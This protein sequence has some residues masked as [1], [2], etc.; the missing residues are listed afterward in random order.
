[1]ISS[2]RL[3]NFR[4]FKDSSFDFGEQVNIIVG[5]NAC[6][7]TS[8][9]EGVLVN[10]TG[11]SYRVK[12]PLLVRE[13]EEWFRVDIV[14][15]SINRVIKYQEGVKTFEIEENKYKRLSSNTKEP[16]VL[17][18]PNILNM[19]TSSPEGR[20]SYID[21]ILKQVDAT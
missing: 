3:Q 9:I 19:L 6:G 17:F 1:M 12:D 2:I 15:N 21:N 11:S 16:V 5:P 18:E 20:R 8:L 14:S 7:K 4:I 13:G 10:L